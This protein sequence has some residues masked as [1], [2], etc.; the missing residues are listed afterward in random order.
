S[1]GLFFLQFARI[2]RRPAFLLGY[3]RFLYA[4]QF[5]G[6]TGIWRM[7]DALAYVLVTFSILDLINGHKLTG[8]MGMLFYVLYYLWNGNKFG[9]FFTLGCFFL[10]VYYKR[11]SINKKAIRRTVIAISVLAI[12]IICFAAVLSSGIMGITGVEY[13]TERI[14]QQGQLWWKTY[15]IV[16]KTHL[17]EISDELNGMLHGS[18][19]ISDNIGADYGI[20]KIMYLCGMDSYIDYKLSTGS[21][22]TEAGFAAAY[23]YC[24]IMGG[25]LFAA[26]CAFFISKTV[27]KLTVSLERG[28]YILIV[29]TARFF[30]LER[31]A[32]S[33]FIF[34][35]FI[36]FVS[37]ASYA[38]LLYYHFF[39]NRFGQRQIAG[40]GDEQR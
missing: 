22:F 34:Q 40:Q 15:N 37:F 33:L 25:F 13:I 19:V 8:L 35:N 14:A 3:D 31:E 27:N 21:R 29:I 24:G 7:I 4:A 20:Y 26:I 39:G 6:N 38:V 36:D 2:A 16:Y 28:E 18:T 5:G 1:A 9:P 32:M 23:Y 11:I 30:M 12:L 17:A 10:M